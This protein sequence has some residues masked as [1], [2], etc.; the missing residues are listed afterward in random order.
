MLFIRL[1]LLVN[2]LFF[3]KSDIKIIDKPIKYDKERIQLSIDY[4]RERH[5]IT[6]ENQIINPKIIVLHFTDGGSVNSVYNYFNKTKIEDKRSFNRN[7][8][9]LNVSSQFII[10]RDGTIYR[11]MPENWFA[12]HTIG[13]NYCAIGIE[14]IGSVKQSLT[15][16]Q[17]RANANLVRFLAKKYNIEYLIGHQEY[18]VFRNSK[19]WK[20]TNPKYFTGKEDPGKLFMQKTRNL[21]QD[22]NLKDKPKENQ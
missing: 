16:A 9:E 10:D 8:S 5:G 14:N 12:R 7:Q 20:E 19:L 17:V 15:E 13:L 11:L 2:L 3:Q 4:L 22:L 18:G 1:F 21:V 6:Q